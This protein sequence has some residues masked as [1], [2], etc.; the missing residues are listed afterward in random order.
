VVWAVGVAEVSDAA[1]SVACVDGGFGGWVQ[2]IMMCPIPVGS[3]VG[4][5]EDRVAGFS[6]PGLIRVPSPVA[7]QLRCAVA[8]RGILTPIWA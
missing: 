1:T 6:R 5:P 7:S 4:V 8:V 2:M 3:E